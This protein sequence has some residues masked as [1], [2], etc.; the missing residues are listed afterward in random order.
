MKKKT[1]YVGICNLKGGC[2]KSVV[3]TVLASTL[4]YTTSANVAVI[5][6]DYPQY[7]IQAMRERD[8]KMVTE[9]SYFKEQYYRQY[10]RIQKKGYAVEK[11]ESENI[12]AVA[13]RYL[14]N[15]EPVDVMFFDL[16]GSTNAKG[17]LDT[18]LNLDYIFCPVV[19]DRIVLQ[20]SLAFIDNVRYFLE[21][22]KN[23]D[24]PLKDIYF[25]WNRIDNRESKAIYNVANNMVKELK[26]KKMKAELLETNKFK[27]ELSAVN[28]G[29]FFRST[30]FPP[31]PTLVRGTGL[32]MFVE[33][34]CRIIKLSI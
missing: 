23:S 22:F 32:E 30:L 28:K 16:P 17:I 31:N 24:Y 33:E 13:D 20:S 11:A 25:F 5:D 4:H 1:I 15:G 9:S 29:N 21:T 34:F 7:S 26:I 10:Q 12:L 3:T 14:E 6:G 8:T 27:K 19:T 18:I 2:G